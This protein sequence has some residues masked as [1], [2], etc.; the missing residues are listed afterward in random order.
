MRTILKLAAGTGLAAALSATT[1]ATS[2]SAGTFGDKGT[3]SFGV[4]RLMGIY[5]Y[6]EDPVN[7]TLI[8][9]G[10]SAPAQVYTQARFAIDGFIIDHLSIGG[11]FAFWSFDEKHA[12]NYSGV[13][14]APR[15]GYTIPFNDSIGFWPRGGFTYRN[16]NGNDEFALTLEGVFY[17]SPMDHFA[18]TFG[19]VLDLGLAGSGSE[20]RNFGLLTAGLM[21]WI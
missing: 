3:L 16:F 14:L 8:G 7:E 4:D 10:A 15:V 13:L 11:S 12:G 17:A 9:I 1:L 2:A 6:D 5:F 20:S 19:P 21:G 18:I